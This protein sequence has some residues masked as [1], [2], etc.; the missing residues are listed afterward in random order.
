MVFG[1]KKKKPEKPVTRRE[2]IYP[3]YV[4]ISEQT[5]LTEGRLM[6][7]ENRSSSPLM[8]VTIKLNPG[9]SD[10][11]E[12]VSFPLMKPN[13]KRE[14]AF[15]SE[16]KAFKHEL[17]MDKPKALAPG[18]AL[19]FTINVSSEIPA[20][21]RLQIPIKGY[22]YVKRDATTGEVRETEGIERTFDVHDNA[23]INVEAAPNGEEDPRTIG[24]YKLELTSESSMSGIEV[25]EIK[26]FSKLNITIEKES[27]GG[28]ERKVIVDVQNPNEFDVEVVGIVRIKGEE[29]IEEEISGELAPGESKNLVL[30]VK[31]TD[32]PSVEYDVKG[33]TYGYAEYESSYYAEN[34]GEKI[35]L[36]MGELETEAKALHDEILSEVLEDKEIPATGE[37]L[38]SLK[39]RFV[40]RG[41]APIEEIERITHVDPNVAELKEIKS[42][43][44]VE[45]EGNVRRLKLKSPL[46]KDES[47]TVEE[48]YVVRPTGDE[49]EV[50]FEVNLTAKSGEAMIDKR[51]ESKIHIRLLRR[52]VSMNVTQDF[53]GET[54][55][56]NVQLVNT[57]QMPAVK[58][59]LVAEIPEDEF[60]VDVEPKETERK[61]NVRKWVFDVIQPDDER[62]IKIRVRPKTEAASFD[63]IRIYQERFLK[64]SSLLEEHLESFIHSVN[65]RL[66]YDL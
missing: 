14:I 6:T 61:K 54:V 41:Y 55:V 20:Y 4:K 23:Q 33:V 19:S 64:N 34:P 31:S 40:S 26:A 59:S 45:V 16:V 2:R 7:I 32:E 46:E 58:V 66:I 35:P 56:Y 52:S 3:I 25:E 11:P 37:S 50:R 51:S 48:I 39:I 13:E 36:L 62:R 65:V 42:K 10:L 49:S 21:G 28:S 29:I 9:T 12:T 27:S 30:E 24:A 60:D 38:V 47:V 18:D 15:S 17:V 63:K 53:E 1:K 5:G 43:R 44:K 8:N 22:E 57:G